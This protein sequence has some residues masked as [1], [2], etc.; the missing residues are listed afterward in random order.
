MNLEQLKSQGSIQDGYAKVPVEWTNDDGDVIKFD[1]YAKREMSAADYE[2]IYLGTGRER[3]IE[4]GELLDDPL[5]SMFARRVHRLARLG[6]D[7]EP[8]PFETAKT[9][10]HSLLTAISGAIATVEKKPNSKKKSTK[11]MNSGTNSSSTE[12]VAEP[13]PKPR[14]RSQ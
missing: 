12:L 8:I 13:L 2:F 11:T 10:K 4:T 7:Q 9:F 14:K 1:I 5:D 3:D 6:E